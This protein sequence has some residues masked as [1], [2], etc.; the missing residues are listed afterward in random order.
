MRGRNS[1][2]KTTPTKERS[3]RSSST[4]LMKERNKWSPATV[5][6]KE[7]LKRNLNNNASDGC[8]PEA[9]ASNA[10]EVRQ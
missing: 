10:T 3:K 1:R 5:L 8:V 2:P 9:A 7:R 6:R 4:A